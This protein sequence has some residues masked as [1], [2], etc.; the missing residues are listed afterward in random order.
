MTLE[1]GKR[2]VGSVTVFDLSGRLVFG[3][4]C[5]VLR[6]E[7]KS[8]MAAGERQFVLNLEN[9]QYMDSGGLG[10]LV[11]L[12]TSARSAG[13]DLRLAAPNE[14]VAHVLGITRLASVISIFPDLQRALNPGPRV[15]SA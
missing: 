15:A 2:T 4:E 14:K 13:G 1:I 7:V 5:L 9:V 10:T 3:E 8:A 12:Y 6:D 11:G